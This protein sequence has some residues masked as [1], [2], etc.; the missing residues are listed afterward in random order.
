MATERD[1][2]KRGRGRPRSG[3]ADASAGTVQALDRGLN[4][5]VALSQGK[6]NLTELSHRIGLPASTTHRLLITL[7]KHGMV[8][9]DEGDQD[10]AIGIE[11]YRV[12]S[13]FLSRSNLFTVGQ[14]V[15]RQLMDETGET[16]N[17]SVHDN[18]EMVFIG[19]IETSNPIRAFFRP[20][21][22][23]PMHSSG[24]GKAVMSQ[25]DQAQIEQIIRTQGLERFTDTTI[26]VAE[27]LYEDLQN[28]RERGWAS[29]DQERYWG[30]RCVASAIRDVTGDVVGA[31]SV[32]GPT[33]RF[34]EQ[35]MQRFGA[36]VKRAASEVAYRIGGP[37]PSD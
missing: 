20:G 8:E 16:A 31:I 34:T 3:A 33:A 11:T 25:L 18:H 22:R 26:V 28:A 32:S 4:T 13:A 29:D 24:S 17:M 6:A 27:D 5:L 9:F 23:T 7:Q 21:A 15:M 37:A 12:G 1:H 35:K 30:M 10:W 14:D 36:A 19:Q 2:P